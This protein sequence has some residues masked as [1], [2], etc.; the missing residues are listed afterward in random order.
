MVGVSGVSVVADRRRSGG[1]EREVLAVLATAGTPL[2]PAQVRAGL[3]RDLA[4]TT[5]MT[6]LQRLAEKGATTRAR[7]GRAF[8]YR[9]ADS[10]TV[11]ARQM[12]GL[13]QHGNDR[14]AVLSQ[15]LVE[16]DAEDGALLRRLLEQPDGEAL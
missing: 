3:D 2:T 13:L 15:F 7:V 8:A 5:V 4:Y 10:A 1:L 12:H 6:T 9:M 14:A 11:T 16:L